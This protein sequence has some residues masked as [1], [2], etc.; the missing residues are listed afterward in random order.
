MLESPVATSEG[1]TDDVTNVRQINQFSENGKTDGIDVGHFKGFCG[2]GTAVSIE[3]ILNH[4]TS[5]IS[6]IGTGRV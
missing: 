4:L 6:A 2:L 3:M 1:M 5:F